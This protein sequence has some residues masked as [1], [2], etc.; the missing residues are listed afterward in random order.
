MPLTFLLE[1]LNTSLTNLTCT[2]INPKKISKMSKK[3]DKDIFGRIIFEKIP[4][5]EIWQLRKSWQL[6]F[7]TKESKSEIPESLTQK[8]EIHNGVSFRRWRCLSG[9][10]LRH[11]R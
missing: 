10:K 1:I 2:I 4:D 11:C 9:R 8:L 3:Q 7:L 6:I 5:R